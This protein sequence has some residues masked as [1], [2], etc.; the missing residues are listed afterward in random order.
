MLPSQPDRRRSVCW[1]SLV[2][3]LPFPEYDPREE[4]AGAQGELRGSCGGRRRGGRWETERSWRGS[5]DGG[6]EVSAG[7]EY[8]GGEAS[9]GGGDGGG[10]AGARELAA[11]RRTY[12]G[13]WRLEMG[14]ECGNDTEET[15]DCGNGYGKQTLVDQHEH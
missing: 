15:T 7:G 11:E 1:P 12:Q 13:A 6:R 4:T 14:I 3:V 5:E 2:L 8:G 10:E 9:F